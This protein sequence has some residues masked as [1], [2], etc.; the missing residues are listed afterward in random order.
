M[1]NSEGAYSLARESIDAAKRPR[2]ATPAAPLEAQPGPQA[3]LQ[4]AKAWGVPSK[5]GPTHAGIVMEQVEMDVAV[6]PALGD[7]V[8]TLLSI[9][10][11]KP[12]AGNGTKALTKLTEMADKN[13]VTLALKPT[14]FL[15]KTGGLIPVPALKRFYERHGFRTV[16]TREHGF[17]YMFR[18]PKRGR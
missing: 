8:V 17:A 14:P 13:G 16:F 9:E 12:K 18:H 6:E 4:Q 2:E 11:L 1:S 7:T 10:S 5:S 3:F 15:P